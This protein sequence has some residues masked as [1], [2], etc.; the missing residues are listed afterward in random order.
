MDDLSFQV[1]VPE[2][3]REETA[4]APL[5]LQTEELTVAVLADRLKQPVTVTLLKQQFER[6]GLRRQTLLQ[7]ADLPLLLAV[8][9]VR[10]LPATRGLIRTLRRTPTMPL[11]E[12]LHTHRLFGK[13]FA[14]EIRR[15]P[16]RSD[17]R[18][19]FGVDDS[20]TSVWERTYAILSPKGK[21]IVGIT[22]IFSPKLEALFQERPAS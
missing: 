19:L 10:P 8:T 20:A 9:Y 4:L 14:V 5:L 21:Q 22:E 2:S 13:K 1:V 18:A 15:R 16:C 7:T 17:D 11:G 6:G 12:A 3:A